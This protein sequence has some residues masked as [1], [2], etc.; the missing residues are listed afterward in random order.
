MTR[1]FT[2]VSVAF[3]AIGFSVAACGVFDGPREQYR[4]TLRSQL[5]QV[6]S[7]L[8]TFEKGDQP[9]SATVSQGD[10]KGEVTVPMSAQHRLMTTVNRLNNHLS[11]VPLA[12]LL[13]DANGF[14]S[15]ATLVKS[16]FADARRRIGLELDRIR[17]TLA[18]NP[19]A[20]RG[21]LGDSPG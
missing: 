17:A 18:E 16:D 13:Q 14:D 12:V 4:R 5:D 3:L 8:A 9:A 20:F 6:V 1:A 7:V 2:M 15:W 10:F 21:A 19:L 11:S